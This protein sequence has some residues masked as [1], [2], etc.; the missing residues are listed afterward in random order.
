MPND[1]DKS[2]DIQSASACLLKI[3]EQLTAALVGQQ[4]DSNIIF[5]LWIFRN[6]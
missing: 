3:S 2:F 4:K 6:S 5:Q 1:M